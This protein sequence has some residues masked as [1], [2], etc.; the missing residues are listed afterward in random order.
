MVL[1]SVLLGGVPSVPGIMGPLLRPPPCP[2][3]EQL[4]LSALLLFYRPKCPGIKTPAFQ[5]SAMG[6]RAYTS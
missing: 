5:H 4:S 6:D 1:V 3:P 2:R